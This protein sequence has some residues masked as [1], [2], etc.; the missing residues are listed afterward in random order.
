MGAGTN[1]S[2]YAGD[3]ERRTKIK[4]LFA[5]ATERM[6]EAGL[7]PVAVL[8][9]EQEA[10]GE[11][12]LPRGVVIPASNRPLPEVFAQVKRIAARVPGPGDGA[13][14]SEAAE[15]AVDEL[16]ALVTPR[17][18]DEWRAGDGPV[19]LWREGFERPWLGEP[20]DPD[21]RAL[22]LHWTPLPRV[23]W[24]AAGAG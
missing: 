14:V 15:A 20:G 22:Y 5:A 1:L 17:H 8:A 4:R 16:L 2:L 21:Q 11:D 18:L 6:V 9:L 19:L 24:G 7:E 12:G 10:G 23:R 13:A 3:G